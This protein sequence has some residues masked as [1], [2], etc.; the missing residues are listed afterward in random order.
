LEAYQ[1]VSIELLQ[2]AKRC[3]SKSN[4]KGEVLRINL[5]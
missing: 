1:I 4:K 2:N 5:L 3:M